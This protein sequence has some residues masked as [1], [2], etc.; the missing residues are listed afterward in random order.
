MVFG[1]TPFRCIAIAPPARR[2]WLLTSSSVSFQGVESYLAGSQFDG[3][4]NLL[5]GDGAEGGG[6]RVGVLEEV[7]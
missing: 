7:G 5:A 6:E 4:I 3:G 2:E 1:S